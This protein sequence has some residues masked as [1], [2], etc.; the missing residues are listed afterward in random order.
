MEDIRN[1]PLVISTWG[2]EI[3][4]N[5]PE[6]EVVRA[7][8]VSYLRKAQ[9]VIALSDF[10]ADATAEYAGIDRRQVVRHY[11][12]VDLDQ[13][14]PRQEPCDEPVI[15][16]AKA[17]TT[18][19]GAEYLIDALP[20]IL[21]VVPQARLIMVGDGNLEALLRQRA[22][23]L[24]VHRAIDWIGR[25]QH[26]EMPHYYARMALSVMPSIYASETLG[27]SALESQAMRVPVVA[28]R[29]G[30]IPESVI[31]GE[32]GVLVAARDAQ[33][34]ADAIVKLLVDNER[35]IRLGNQGRAFVERQF[36]WRR[37][38]QNTVALY[39]EVVS[40]RSCA[41]V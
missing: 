16:F 17:L 37:T 27:V 1:Y 11:W 5:E 12:G 21:K 6:P 38:L 35:R 31:D 33:A 41:A 22:A 32:T 14:R 19:Y 10:L 36:D 39:H 29:V 28:S 13:F 7:A 40:E 20:R 30:G 3:L 34:L 25:V 24:G 23:R 15:G 18:K 26:S 2:S 9:R 8:K 4:P